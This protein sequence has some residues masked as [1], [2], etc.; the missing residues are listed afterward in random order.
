MQRL[1]IV[2]LVFSYDFSTA[3]K[4]MDFLG[5]GLSK[6]V[7]REKRQKSDPVIQKGIDK[8]EPKVML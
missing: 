6:N 4:K 5:V 7:V 3:I 1:N 2:S 8:L